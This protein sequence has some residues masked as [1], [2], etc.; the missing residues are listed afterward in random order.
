VSARITE[1]ASK[2]RAGVASSVIQHQFEQK[3]IERLFSTFKFESTSSEGLADREFKMISDM[4]KRLANLLQQVKSNLPLVGSAVSASIFPADSA[5]KITQII[6]GIDNGT[7]HLKE[8]ES[9][10]S[11]YLE[12]NDFNQQKGF[13]E[14]ARDKTNNALIIVKSILNQLHL[15]LFS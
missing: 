2:L 3:E 9:E 8:A 15:L 6:D 12:S 4:K 10:L 5:A 1:E 11:T 14:I 13:L 7:L